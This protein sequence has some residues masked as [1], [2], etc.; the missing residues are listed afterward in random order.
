MTRYDKTMTRAN[1]SKTYLMPLLAQYIDIK[2][3][4]NIKNVYIR[5]NFLKGD[6]IG[7]L[8]KD[9]D[10]SDFVKYKDYLCS[11][12]LFYKMIEQSDNILFIFYFPEEYLYEY[13]CYQDG[14]YSMFTREAKNIIIQYTSDMYQYS[15]LTVEITQVLY[16]NRGRREMLESTLGIS[17]PK[18]A[19]LT[20]KME[21]NEETFYI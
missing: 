19:E 10:D 12:Q 16:K 11:C 3:V 14:L 2:Y 1:K 4:Y 8:F 21:E 15:P 18:D 9:I 7:I 17:L 13:T 20:S 5:F 6:F